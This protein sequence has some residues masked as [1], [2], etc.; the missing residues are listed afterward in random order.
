VTFLVCS[1]NAWPGHKGRLVNGFASSESIKSNAPSFRCRRNG[2]RPPP[3]GATKY[4]DPNFSAAA[5]PDNCHLAYIEQ[6]P[7]IDSG[8]RTAIG[9][10]D[11]SLEWSIGP[12][13]SFSG[14]TAIPGSPAATATIAGGYT[15]RSSLYIANREASNRLNLFKRTHPKNTNTMAAVTSPSRPSTFSSSPA[16]IAALRISFSKTASALPQSHA[17]LG[18]RSFIISICKP[19]RI[20]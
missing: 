20:A 6:Q 10:T 11:G 9:V 7:A 5:L 3:D 17:Q 2:A 13:D 8:A 15:D 18:K 14:R 12:T 4:L 16:T 19:Y 1:R